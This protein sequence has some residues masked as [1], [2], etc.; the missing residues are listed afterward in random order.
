MPEYFTTDD[1]I[2]PIACLTEALENIQVFYDEERIED[3]EN[4]ERLIDSYKYAIELLMT[5]QVE[6]E[7]Y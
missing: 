7:R 4:A 6:N 3:R 1:F 5:E 2:N